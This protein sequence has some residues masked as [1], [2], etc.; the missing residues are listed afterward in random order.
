MAGLAGAYLSYCDCVR[1]GTGEKM[2]ILAVFSQGD[3]DS[4]MVGR[5]GIFY[6]RKGLDYDATITRIVSNPISLRQAFWLPYKKFVR[7][8]EEMVSK[9]AA[10]AEAG[11]D[12]RLTQAAAATASA[13]AAKPADPKKIDVGTV[14]ALGV[15][16][17]SIATFL[18]L[19][20]G[21]IIG[22]VAY[23]PL[24]ILGLIAGVILLISGP[25]MILAYIK[26]RKRNLGPILDANGWAVNAKA[27]INVPFGAALTE[28]AKLPPG[29]DR[30]LIDPFAEKKSPWP[31]LIAFALVLYLVYLLLNHLG[32]I[33]EWTDGRMGVQKHAAGPAVV[34]V[35]STN[36]ATNTPSVK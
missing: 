18:G 23:G 14:A 12:A 8:I 7:L 6:D 3:D 25:S 16:F 2:S 33:Y 35:A 26:L 19:M 11:S 17:G 27:K 9:R 15:A 30:D 31:K 22:I 5:N 29:S 28:V 10:T 32:F 1:R 13:D 21:H 24:A 4:L 20:V 34:P 36:T